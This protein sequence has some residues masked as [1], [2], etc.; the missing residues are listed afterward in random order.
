MKEFL[1]KKWV[2]I[3]VYSVFGAIFLLGV[4]LT[5]RQFVLLPVHYEAPP[6]PAPVQPTP[7]VTP[8]PVAPGETPAPTPEPTPIPE[9]ADP[10]RIFFPR[11]EQQ[12]DVQPVDLDSWAEG[13][14]PSATTAS[15]LE[16]GPVP[17]EPGN[18]LLAGHV[19]WKGVKGTFSLLKE[20]T[21]GDEVVIEYADGT[22]G[23]FKAES[24][25][26]Y[27][28]DEIPENLLSV[29]FAGD[30]VVTM[31]TCLG[32]YDRELG[33]SRSRVVMVLKPTTGV[34]APVEGTSVE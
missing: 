4:F 11:F 13:G 2:R 34:T 15:W 26:T 20:M 21:A 33:T 3:T 8:A 9:L 32:D 14:V 27:L 28:T 7:V 30:P 29:Y 6:T 16:I 1:N 18:A 24:V 25:N 17:G 22:F 12:C 23:Y 10:V 19:T 31:I 5:V